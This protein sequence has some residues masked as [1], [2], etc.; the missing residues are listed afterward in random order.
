LAFA[1]LEINALVIMAE[2]ILAKFILH[3]VAVSDGPGLFRF[4]S[5]G[6]NE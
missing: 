6:S 4:L 3:V 1:M 2:E 5:G